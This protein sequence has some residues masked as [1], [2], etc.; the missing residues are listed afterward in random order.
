MTGKNLI[1]TMVFMLTTAIS[2]WAQE[3]STYNLCLRDDETG[4]WLIGLFSDFAIYDCDYWQ[5]ERVTD[6][7]LTL[8]S[9]DRRIRVKL[10]QR[11][12]S[13]A[14]VDIGGQ[15][16]RVSTVKGSALPCYPMADDRSYDEPDYQLDSI[17][18]SGYKPD[19]PNQ[20]L[21]GF[22]NSFLSGDSEDFSINTDGQGRFHF[23]MP[24]FGP[25]M[26]YFETEEG[27]DG[28]ILSPGRHFMYWHQDQM[29][30]MGEDA[31]LA[32]ECVF[33]YD[34]KNIQEW[35]PQMSRRFRLW[36]HKHSDS[37]F[38]TD[39]WNKEY[40]DRL[41]RWL[42]DAEGVPYTLYASDELNKVLHHKS[43]S[44]EDNIDHKALILLRDSTGRSLGTVTTSYYSDN[45]QQMTADGEL[46]PLTAEEKAGIAYADSCLRIIMELS[47]QGPLD[48]AY[49]NRL[50]NG[51]PNGKAVEILAEEITAINRR[52]DYC[53]ST[54][55]GLTHRLDYVRRTG[56]PAVL[57][58]IT[59][60]QGLLFDLYHD[61]K[62][63]PQR[64]MRFLDDNVENV[65]IRQSVHEANDRMAAIGQKSINASVLMD[66][67]IVEGL[68]DGKEILDKLV[69]PYRGRVVYIDFWGTWCGPCKAN[70]KLMPQVHEALKDMDV[71]YL[72]LADRSPEESW[73]NVI[74]E[75]GVDDANSVHYNLPQEQ[76]E[77][78]KR[79]VG[80]WQFPTYKLVDR[81]GR[82]QPGD[83][84]S[85]KEID[86]LRQAV[87][88][89]SQ[90]RNEE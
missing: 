45:V 29:L 90:M 51:N 26:V 36:L 21:H 22:Y 57:C 31:R 44:P 10:T 33:F 18:I 11:K 4:E 55:T 23:T 14:A 13:I 5:Y 78:V 84:P 87:E 47:A 54:L 81:N 56:Y 8:Q 80:L 39:I 24:A 20:T 19:A 15:K 75:Y 65:S 16:H 73:K 25:M 30:F 62:P 9:G 71:V 49:N 12:D 70:M 42:L 58:D 35:L 77:A 59:V 28:I 27:P 50:I 67:K 79:Y 88:N 3:K 72:Y 86:K 34:C 61:K 64:L 63:I 48:T 7:A 32:N 66:N 37:V 40:F 82:L 1:A 74:K 6:K 60:A 41:E 38:Q 17:T 52:H 83:A 43:M 46:R 89:A 76:N 68:T 53:Y 2:A 69:A 85:P